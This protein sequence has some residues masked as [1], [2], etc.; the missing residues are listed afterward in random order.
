MMMVERNERRAAYFQIYSTMWGRIKIHL[1]SITTTT[2]AMNC[3]TRHSMRTASMKIIRCR[4]CHRLRHKTHF[5]LITRPCLISHLTVPMFSYPRI[6]YPECF[7][8]C[9]SMTIPLILKIQMWISVIM[10]QMRLIQQRR[11][12]RLNPDS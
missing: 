6:G 2:T 9:V 3:I 5:T 12:G 7:Y 10:S 8:V 4:H 1:S 11:S